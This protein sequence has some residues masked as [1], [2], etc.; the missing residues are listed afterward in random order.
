MTTLIKKRKPKDDG[1]IVINV[2]FTENEYDLINHVDMRGNFSQYVKRL[3]LNDM[4]NQ[5]IPQANGDTVGLLLKLLQNS[6]APALTPIPEPEP[7]QPKA[8]INKIQGV[9]KGLKIK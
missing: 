9:M 5:N 8:D 2:S 7:E 4:N 6:Q 1:R 3:I